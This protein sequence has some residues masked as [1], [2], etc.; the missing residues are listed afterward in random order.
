MGRGPLLRTA[1]AL[2]GISV[3]AVAAFMASASAGVAKKR[4]VPVAIT[5]TPKAPTPTPAPTPAQLAVAKYTQLGKPIFCGGGNGPYVA[6]TFDDGPGP[7]TPK[8]LDLLRRARVPATF[9]VI[10]KNVIRSPSIVRREALLGQ[11]GD[12]TWSHPLLPGLD[13]P[14]VDQELRSTRDLIGRVTNR[15]VR[16]FR[17]PFGQHTPAI[18]AISQNLGML[19]VDWS[20]GAEDQ[21]TDPNTMYATLVSRVQAGSIILMHE[22]QPGEIEALQ[23]FLPVLRARGLI[24]VG[25]PKLLALDPPDPTD[26]PNNQGQ[27]LARWPGA[28]RGTLGHDRQSPR[29]VVRP[30]QPPL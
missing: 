15:P 12:H 25:I 19:L 22:N 20:V 21:G 11:V 8:L 23:R 7:L 14:A 9:F 2:L 6:F 26:M 13:P 24:P 18:D 29:A 17:P 27:C 5:G 16:L 3:L 4:P 1:L 10:G 28:V 30:P